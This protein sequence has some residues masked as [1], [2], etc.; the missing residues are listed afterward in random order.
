VWA[1]RYDGPAHATDYATALAVSPDAS[2]V[3]VTGS[4]ARSNGSDYVTVAYDATTG[5]QVWVKRYDGP[6]HADD[7][8]SALGVSPDGSTVFV[9]GGSTGSNGWDY[10]T[11][12]YSA[13]TGTQVWVKRYSGP[14]Q[15]G[16]FA[17]ALGV[18]PDGSTVFVT[19]YRTGSD[20]FGDY[21]TV[22]YG[23]ATGTKEWV[24]RYDG[25]AHADDS[26]KALAV[27]VDG[28]TVF[29]TGD[30]TG[31]NSYDYATVAYDAATGALVLT[32]LGGRLN[33]EASRLREGSP[34][35]ENHDPV[36]G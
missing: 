3:F 32:R 7:F 1:K 15:F 30:S 25:P 8:A 24:S 33:S 29:V 28:S 17:N 4:S 18:S 12:A 34:R 20:G 6:G 22:A 2:T 5:A 26:A 35:A 13:V 10:A 11:V 19:G 27:S 23:A 36:P 9:T 16:D 31:S 14:A 21:A